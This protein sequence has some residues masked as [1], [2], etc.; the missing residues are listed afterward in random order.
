[1]SIKI[2]SVVHPSEAFMSH[3]GL[4]L[5]SEVARISG[6]DIVCLGIA[7]ITPNSR[8]GYPSKP[9]RLGCPG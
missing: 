4:F 6:L 1:M 2:D 5:I 3:A 7:G 8:S 9:L